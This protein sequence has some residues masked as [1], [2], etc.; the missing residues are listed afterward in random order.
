MKYLFSGDR[1]DNEICLVLSRRNFTKACVCLF[2]SLT[3]CL[4]VYGIVAVCVFLLKKKTPKF[5][6]IHTFQH[7]QR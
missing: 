6:R 3:V 5:T 7:D 1:R 4:Y 2:A